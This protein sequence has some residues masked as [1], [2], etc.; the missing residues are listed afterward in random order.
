MAIIQGTPGNDYLTAIQGNNQ[1]NGYGGNDTLIGGSDNDYLVGGG[2]NDILT[3]GTGRDTFVLNYSGGGIDTITDFSVYDDFLEIIPPS[4]FPIPPIFS[5][6]KFTK[7]TTDALGS[8]RVS[9]ESMRLTA[10]LTKPK[11]EPDEPSTIV[12]RGIRFPNYLSYNKN[13]GALYYLSQQLA[14]LPPNLHFANDL[15][16]SSFIFS[17]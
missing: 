5:I 6:T 17:E 11:D 9:S 16:S 4:I 12:G 1:I 13:T 8:T 15:S 14:W 10:F 7:Y 3:G 2:G